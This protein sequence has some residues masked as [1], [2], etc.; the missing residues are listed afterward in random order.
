MRKA[1]AIITIIMT[2]RIGL[3]VE[4]ITKVDRD[5]N[6][7]LNSIVNR[8]QQ[9]A[10]KINCKSTKLERVE[11]KIYYRSASKVFDENERQLLVPYIGRWVWVVSF[12]SVNAD[13]TIGVGGGCVVVIPDSK[14]MEVAIA[15]RTK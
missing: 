1:I 10:Y 4:T 5:Y 6:P 12:S 3:P 2:V 9:E 13:K 14:Q 11:Y 8:A 15:K 7:I